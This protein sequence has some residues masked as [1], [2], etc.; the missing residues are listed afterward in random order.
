MSNPYEL[1]DQRKSLGVTRAVKPKSRYWMDLM[2]PNLQI[3]STDEWIDFEK[4]PAHAQKMAPFVRPLASGKPIYED[5]STGFRFKPAYIKLKDAIDPLAVLV[6][7]PG[8][9]SS[10]LNDT[11]LDPNQRRELLRAAMT[12]THVNAIHQ[13]HEWMAARASIDAMVTIEGE[14]YPAVELDFRRAANHTVTKTT[15]NFWGDSGVSIFDDIQTYADRMWDAEFG[16]FPKRMTMGSKVWAACRASDE[17]MAHMDKNVRGEAATIVRGIIDSEDAV[18]VGE[19]QV[20]GASGATIEMWLYRGTYTDYDTGTETPMLAPNKVVFSGSADKFMGYRCFG[21]IVDP[22]AKY[23]SLEIFARNWME[24][25]DPAVEH[26]L[27]QSAP[28]F[29]PVN[30]NVTLT[31]EVVAA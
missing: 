10:M 22:Y 20:G 29:V 13:T 15:G 2:F 25:G 14:D 5:R 31:A 8:V 1:W 4:L 16:G 6:K 11:D 21:A 24:T 27:H 18:K 9:D 26:L 28:L 19:L 3:N 23:Q 7:R 12:V 17:F 30:P